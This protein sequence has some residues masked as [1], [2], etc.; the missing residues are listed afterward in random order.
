MQKKYATRNKNYKSDFSFIPLRINMLFSIMNI[1]NLE[2][3]YQS[4]IQTLIQNKFDHPLTVVKAL[5]GYAQQDT[6]HTDFETTKYCINDLTVFMDPY[7]SNY[8]TRGTSYN[9]K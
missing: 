3:L 1:N 7:T 8:L 6:S 2:Y 4:F 5:I 9:T